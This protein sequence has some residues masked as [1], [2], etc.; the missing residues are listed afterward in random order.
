MKE[1]IAA[2]EASAVTEAIVV[3]EVL[4]ASE[5]E[6]GVTGLIVATAM[7]VRRVAIVGKD[8]ASVS[9]DLSLSIDPNT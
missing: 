3:I 1:G 8:V 2:I 6:T 5:A 4:A 7:I 9:A